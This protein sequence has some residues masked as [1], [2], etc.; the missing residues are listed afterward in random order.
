MT[1]GWLSINIS[2]HNLGH[3]ITGKLV[4]IYFHAWVIREA[5]FQW[6]LIIENKSFLMATFRKRQILHI[7][8]PIC[9]L[10]VP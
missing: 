10:G 2:L 4:G 3:Y 7:L 9:T 5:I 1:L 6:A 8:G